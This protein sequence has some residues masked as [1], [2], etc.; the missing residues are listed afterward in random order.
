MSRY[1]ELSTTYKISNNTVYDETLG[2]IRELTEAEQDDY[3]VIVK[4]V[5]PGYGHI[6]YKV[7]KNAPKLSNDDLALICDKGGAW[8]GYR[9]QGGNIL[10]YTD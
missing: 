8:F 2:I 4:R 7:I 3:D 1:Q 5:G 10:I 6:V 9:V